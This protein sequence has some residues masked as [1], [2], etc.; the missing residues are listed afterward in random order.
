MANIEILNTLPPNLYDNKND[1]IRLICKNDTVKPI[2]SDAF[3]NN[4]TVEEFIE[5]LRNLV[6][7]DNIKNFLLRIDAVQTIKNFSNSNY[8]LFDT[9][10]GNFCDKKNICGILAD[11]FN[12]STLY[13]NKFQDIVN[14]ITNSIIVDFVENKESSKNSFLTYVSTITGKKIPI[15]VNR[16][17]TILDVKCAILQKEGIPLDQQRLIFCGKQLDDEDTIESYGIKEN[18][19]LYL[20]LRVRGGMHHISSGRIDYCSTIMPKQNF[21]RNEEIICIASKTINFINKSDGNHFPK[22]ITFYHHPK[23]PDHIIHNMVMMETDNE[24]FDKLSKDAYITIN[25]NT[26]QM[27]SKEALLRYLNRKQKIES[28]LELESNSNSEI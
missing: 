15:N 2:I 22:T 5:E 26:L 23:C 10:R 9:K 8:Y 25:Y 16:I 3:K 13:K 7:K 19:I 27:L 20:V 28:E 18:S 24:Y 21:D 6:G 11:D 1:N 14:P 17:M 4:K 12:T